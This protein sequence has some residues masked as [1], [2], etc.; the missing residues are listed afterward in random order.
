MRARIYRRFNGSYQI[1][2]SLGKDSTTG[3]YRQKWIAVKGKRRNA[4]HMATEL[5]HQ[6]NTTGFIDTTHLTTKEFL[7]QWLTVCKSH[8]SAQSYERSAGIVRHHLVPGFG[9][10]PLSKV[11]RED[12]QRYYDHQLTA[13]LKPGS[14]KK[15]HATIHAAL[16]FAVEHGLIFRNVA[17]IGD[18]PRYK[19]PEMQFWNNDEMNIFIANNLESE[20]YPLFYTALFTGMRRSELL[21]LK[22]QDIDLLMCQVAVRRTLKKLKDGSCIF[23]D[24]KS[25][26]SRRT[27]ALTPNNAQVLQALFDSRSEKLAKPDSMV[28]CDPAGLPLRPNTIS[29]AWALACKKARVKVIT[30]H[31]ARH[32]HATLLF[33][34][35]VNAKVV[36]ERLGHSNVAFTLQTYVHVIPGMQEA[37]ALKFDEL[38]TKI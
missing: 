36:S 23:E 31:D 29:H 10:M 18:A 6:Y 25:T 33:K 32:T 30:F 24:V 12:L 11:T 7:E 1:I 15:I 13:G 38:A 8:L 22:W 27:I 37:A 14:I 19:P 21:G 9:N 4:E 20:Y 17:A 28:F 26:K 5:M 34:Q 35:G 16:T 3:K 2:L